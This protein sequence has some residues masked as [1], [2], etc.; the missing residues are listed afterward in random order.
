M[1][2]LSISDKT[3]S[4]NKK[5]IHQLVYYL[6]KE[7]SFSVQ[8]LQINFINNKEIRELNK[9]HLSHDYTTDILTFD[10]SNDKESIDA[11]IYI[12][13]D[14]A[15]TNSKKFKVSF[16]TEIKRLVIHG[17][18]HLTG[19]DDKTPSEKKIMKRLENRLLSKINFT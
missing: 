3:K 16:E 17:I 18:L 10:Y 9:K 15:L 11:E 14:E 19:Y 4:L 5:K 8:V 13:L 1:K 2:N 7:I 6:S 12:S